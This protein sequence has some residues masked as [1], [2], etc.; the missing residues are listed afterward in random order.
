VFWGGPDV[1]K[2]LIDRGADVEAKTN[3]GETALDLA[4]RKGNE[5][6]VKLL[7]GSLTS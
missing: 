3:D 4:A 5:A 2:L 1:V 6:V 7:Q